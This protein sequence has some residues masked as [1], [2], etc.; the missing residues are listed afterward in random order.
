MKNKVKIALLFGGRSAEHEVSLT[1][2]AAIFRNLDPDKFQVISLYIDK[3]GS[4]RPVDSPLLTPEEL[5]RGQGFS[6]LPWVD[7][8][9]SSSWHADIYFPVLHGPYGEDGTIQGLFEVADVPYVGA[10]V[11]AIIARLW[12]TVVELIP[13]AAL[14]GGYFRSSEKGGP[15]VG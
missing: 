15:A 2:A 3:A 5:N 1:S 10:A 4:W 11:L 13:A 8:A 6:F 14:A 9:A 7:A 12:A